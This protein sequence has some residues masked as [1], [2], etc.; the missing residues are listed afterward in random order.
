MKRGF[1]LIELLVASA[2]FV[3]VLGFGMSLWVSITRIQR[4]N[5][6][7][8]KIYSESRFWVEQM[9]RDIQ[10]GQIAYDASYPTAVP[11]QT[12]LRILT[13]TGQT[14]RYFRGTDIGGN[15]ALEKQVGSGATD[16]LSSPEITVTRFAA[17]IAP[18]VQTTGV[19]PTVTL[20]WQ[21]QDLKQVS[22]ETITL[23]TTVSLRNY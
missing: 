6:S 19:V 15:Q 4:G 8:Q 14:V 12:E 10:A 17:Y 20:E 22:P 16:V 23:Q 1:S 11:A 18:S 5:I 7:K 21:A 9:I 3:L 13:K 2:L